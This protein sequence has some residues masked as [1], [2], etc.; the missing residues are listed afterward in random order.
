MSSACLKPSREV[1]TNRPVISS[2][3]ANAA[4][5]TTKSSPPCASWIFAIDRGDLVVVGDVE[6]QHQRLR[7]QRVGELADVLFEAA[8][9]GEDESGAA[10]R[11]RLRDRP[12]QRTMVRDADDQSNF[13]REVRHQRFFLPPRRRRPPPLS[14]ALPWPCRRHSALAVPVIAEAHRP[15]VVLLPP[16]AAGAAAAAAAAELVLAPP[17]LRWLLLRRLLQGLNREFGKRARRRRLAFGPRERRAY[18]RSAEPAFLATRRLVG[19]L[20]VVGSRRSAAT[21]ACDDRRRRRLPRRDRRRPRRS[22][23]GCDGSEL[24][25]GSVGERGGGLRPRRRAIQ[26]VE[27]LGEQG[28]RLRLAARRRHFALFVFVLRVADCHNASV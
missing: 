13:S 1:F 26:V 16:P 15:E 25:A 22:R 4:P 19:W 27:H 28:G 17:A 21:P 14:L 8:L 2:R 23:F 11:R 7:R 10:L 24:T 20:V 18:Q 5:C 6:R 12:R 3:D 9:I